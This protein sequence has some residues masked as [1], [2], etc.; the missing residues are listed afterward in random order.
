MPALKEKYGCMEAFDG[1]ARQNGLD[2]EAELNGT[3]HMPLTT[4]EPPPRA[5]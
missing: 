2:T 4:S 5:P 3:K 1:V